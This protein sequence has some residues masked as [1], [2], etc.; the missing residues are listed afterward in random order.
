[1]RIQKIQK[2]KLLCKQSTILSLQETHAT[3]HEF[4]AALAESL[5]EF[6]YFASAC[7]DNPC[8]GGV[9]TCVK[10]HEYPPD[11][12]F[13]FQ[14]LIPGRVIGLKICFAGKTIW[15]LNAHNFDFSLSDL[16]ALCRWLST[17]GAAASA[18][19][20]NVAALAAGDWNFDDVY[21]AAQRL[22][23]NAASAPTKHSATNSRALGRALEAYTEVRSKEATHYNAA[24]ETLSHLDRQ[25]ACIPAWIFTHCYVSAQVLDDPT[26]LSQRGISDHAPV[27]FAIS[28]KKPSEHRACA[29]PNIICT[30]PRYKRL[31]HS[32]CL[33]ADLDS[34]E[35][36][37]RWCLHKDIIL[38]C[39][40]RTRNEKLAEAD[41]NS[42]YSAMTCATIARLVLYNKT[43]TARIISGRSALAAKHLVVSDGYVKFRDQ[44]TFEHEFA[45]HKARTNDQELRALQEL[46]R[47]TPTTNFRRKSRALEQR[48]KLWKSGARK[49]VLS[50]IS[51]HDGTVAQGSDMTSALQ[52]SWAPTFQKLPD[53][54]MQSLAFK[55]FEPYVQDLSSIWTSIPP[56]PSTMFSNYSVFV[57]PSSPGVDSLPYS[58][59]GTPE[60]GRTLQGVF[61]ESAAGRLVDLSW[62]DQA[63]V[64]ITKAD[65]DDDAEG[66]VVRDAL[67]T[68]P[69]GLKN[70]DNKTVG[71]VGNRILRGTL[72]QGVDRWQQG[73]IPGRNFLGNVVCLDALSRKC[74]YPQNW[75]NLPILAAFDF[76]SAFP[77][78]LH[79]FI[80]WLLITSGAP[81]WI[82]NFIMTFYTWCISYFAGPD[83]L[84]FFLRIISGIIQ[85]CPL[86]GTLFAHCSH[87]L[88]SAMKHFLSELTNE[89]YDADGGVN[90]MLQACADDVAGVFAS[91][92]FLKAVFQPLQMIKHAAG[93][94]L[95]LSKCTLVPLGEYN[96]NTI[97][98]IKRW[99]N[100]QLPAWSNF[101]IADRTKYLGFIMG[102]SATEHD[103]FAKPFSKLC[104]RTES[105][106]QAPYATAPATFAYNL[107]AITVMS[108][109]M[110]LVSIP[111]NLI[112]EQARLVAKIL[113]SPYMAFGRSG[114][115]RM[116]ED[117]WNRSAP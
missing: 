101:K 49:L 23:P 38:E 85:G 63:M 105:I 94:S 26:A 56:P 40:K 18:D 55:F 115:H 66:H 78:L 92:K 109:V 117:F 13:D 30:D 72:Q 1:M 61:F 20:D 53:P 2:F 65:A 100:E 77:S 32:Y 114:P 103:N 57:K 37:A 52:Q 95:N 107:E 29:I 112:R 31:H 6:A 39:A 47:I 15:H 83:G 90:S 7:P 79:P 36:A 4:S 104:R 54:D 17:A 113:R 70:T 67:D 58:A 14:D 102:P 48:S 41:L 97:F 84:V 75:P 88:L 69:L 59:W 35:P 91:L 87:P 68:R 34:L 108:Y 5:R 16:G 74:G 50:G 19:P 93:L 3:L 71:G 89:S 28:V 9:A 51:Q 80:S 45:L 62:N 116:D 43:D 42:T 60:G 106:A 22:L 12:T 64:F 86:S 33:A 73:F 24:N 81:S 8:A 10:K 82:L 98:K 27:A 96:E 46:H 44:A 99:I 111:E 25:Y 76:S 11:A 21:R 110:Q